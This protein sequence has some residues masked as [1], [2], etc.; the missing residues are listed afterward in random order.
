[1]PRLDSFHAD[2][3]LA[4]SYEIIKV[5]RPPQ[6]YRQPNRWFLWLDNGKNAILPEDYLDKYCPGWRGVVELSGK[7]K[8]DA[9]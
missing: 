9:R 1:M 5:T 6:S 7:E 3:T 2:G 4:A 8:D